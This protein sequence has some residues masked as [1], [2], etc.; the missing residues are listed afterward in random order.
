MDAF[1]MFHRNEIVAMFAACCVGLIILSMAADWSRENEH[2]KLYFRLLVILLDSYD[3]VR[4]IKRQIKWK[5]S[6]L[7]TSMTSSLS[8]SFVASP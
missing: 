6:S 3:F 7:P 5:P 2:V 4:R 8:L 1:L